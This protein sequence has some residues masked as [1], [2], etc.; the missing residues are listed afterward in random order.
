P[1]VCVVW[2]SAV[3]CCLISSACPR[4]YPLPLHDA[5]PLSMARVRASAVGTGAPSPWL[6]N[7]D[8]AEAGCT[9]A[10]ARTI[11]SGKLRFIGSDPEDRKSTRLNSS[12]VKNSYA[13]VC[14]KHKI[15]NKAHVNVW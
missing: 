4:I 6:A 13:V 15:R 3:G 10:S 9:T 12:H 1:D 8:W 2:V 5:L 14:L 7:I 11:A